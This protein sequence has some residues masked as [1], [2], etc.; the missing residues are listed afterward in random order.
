[1]SKESDY[2]FNTT[3]TNMYVRLVNGSIRKWG[4]TKPF[5]MSTRFYIGQ[6][7]TTTEK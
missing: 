1:M 6:V 2:F 5:I 4:L 3:G 7:K